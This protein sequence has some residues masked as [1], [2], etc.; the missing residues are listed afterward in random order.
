MWV[1][2]REKNFSPIHSIKCSQWLE[3]LAKT[4]GSR[5]QSGS[6]IWVAG[7]QALEPQFAACQMCIIRMQ[8]G[9]NTI[10]TWSSFPA[11]I[12][13]HGLTCCTITPAPYNIFYKSLST[14]K[15]CACACV[16]THACIHTHTHTNGQFYP[17]YILSQKNAKRLTWR[18]KAMLNLKDTKK[19]VYG[20][21]T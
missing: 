12:P 1:K 20:F 11:G 8:D 15:T 3:G 21:L 13:S 2:G 4:Q 14:L 10:R 7:M 6:A 9:S 5:T 16:H 18:T 19:T 17:M